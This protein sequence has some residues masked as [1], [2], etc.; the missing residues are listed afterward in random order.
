M[1]QVG[2]V[3]GR[4]GQARGDPVEDSKGPGAAEALGWPW[5][6]E[7]LGW[8]GLVAEDSREQSPRSGMEP[9]VHE[10]VGVR[11]GADFP[12]D[13]SGLCPEVCLGLAFVLNVLSAPHAA[14]INIAWRK[15]SLTCLLGTCHV[16]DG[17]EE[18]RILACPEFAVL[19]CSLLG[20]LPPPVGNMAPCSLSAAPAVCRSYQVGS[21]ASLPWF[22]IWLCSFLAMSWVTLGK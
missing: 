8:G 7:A 21:E 17:G 3:L 4:H 6:G 1:R 2:T 18:R 15:K 13:V 20:V 9:W 11:S 22:R 14:W 16:P 19:P 12:A 5:D 10:E